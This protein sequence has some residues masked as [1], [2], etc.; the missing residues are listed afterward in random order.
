M[1]R[2][3]GTQA[4]APLPY[5][6]GSEDHMQ[7]R[8]R[9]RERKGAVL[10]ASYSSDWSLWIPRTEMLEHHQ[11][12]GGALIHDLDAMRRR[13]EAH[14]QLVARHLT[15]ADQGGRLHRML[16]NRPEA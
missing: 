11:I 10:L 14:E 4:Q 3:T 2:E 12:L 13:V 9:S 6:R 7:R 1:L 16:P 15:V 8:F 5:G